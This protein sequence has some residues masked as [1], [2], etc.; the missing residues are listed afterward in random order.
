MKNYEV[1]S[2]DPR[3]YDLL[4]N[5]VSKVAEIGADQEQLKTLR[6]E[7]ETFVCDGEYARGLE[8]IINAYLAGLNKPEQQAVWVSG[9]FG[10]GKSHLIKMLRYLWVDLKFPDGASARSLARLPTNI[11][12]LFVELNN[13]ARQFG[14]LKA[15]AGTLGE[16]SPDNVR[17]AFLQ[18][19]FRAMTL[20][21]NLAAAKFV[22]WLREKNLWEKISAHLKTKKRDPAQEIRNFYVST[23]LAEALVA[24][25]PSY[26]TPKD[27]REAIR[28]QFPNLSS[29][30]IDE[31]LDL[32]RR[33]FGN[34]GKLPCTLLVVDE[35]QQFIGDKVERAM[36][37][38]EIA[39]HCCTKL[40]S[41]VLLVGTG[42]SALTSTASLGRLQARFGVKVALSDAD[43]EK[44]TRQTVLAKKP[45]SRPTKGRSAATFKIRVW[46]RP[47][48]MNRTMRLIILF[49][50]YAA[51]FGKR[52]C[53]T[54]MLAGRRRSFVLS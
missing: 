7:L 5:G 25:D 22:L 1:Y 27:A 10:S 51:A 42:Q 19:V 34:D 11:N 52:S 38:Q 43:V 48:R 32:I 39:E 3:K 46:R 18:L 30:T 4:N 50:Q 45:L 21:E 44:V 13:R 16:G 23:P 9:F 36:D 6:F 14:G 12:D 35:V 28:A 24:A 8:R 26:G 53:A 15:A 47:C 41:R 54:S 17:L 2:N 20:P 40:D 31:A 29:P 33:I 49:C 37:L